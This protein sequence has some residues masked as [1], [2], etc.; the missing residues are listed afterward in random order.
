MMKDE[1]KWN[2]LPTLE[3]RR[4]GG[5]LVTIYKSITKEEEVENKKLLL[6]TERFWTD[7]RTFKD[8]KKKG[9]A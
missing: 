9:N 6:E 1:I 4:E 7:M 8:D 3:Q 2:Y 5:D